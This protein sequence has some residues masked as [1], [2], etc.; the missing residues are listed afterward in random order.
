MTMLSVCW[1]YLRRYK[2]ALFV[3]LLLLIVGFVVYKVNQPKPEP[4]F[5]PLELRFENSGQSYSGEPYRIRTEYIV[6]AN[7]PEDREALQKLVDEYN[8]NTL[9]DEE[10][11]KWS[12]YQRWF[13]KES[14]SMPRDYK[15]S[16]GYFD[17]DRIDHHG[18]DLLVIVTWHG[19][20]KERTY[21]FQ[22]AMPW[23]CSWGFE[24]NEQC[25]PH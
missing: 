3:G 22:K 5:H 6:I 8:Q 9:S 25:L 18:D 24:N 10:L 17:K 12:G 23:W 7:P 15:E 19:F 2:R 16:G 13:Y 1:A 21:D 4:S 11:S 14:S 20:G